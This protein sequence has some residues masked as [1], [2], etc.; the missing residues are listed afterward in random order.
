LD[1]IIGGTK[2]TSLP[3]MTD[4]RE[5]HVGTPFGAPSG[6]VKIGRCGGREVAFLP[7]HGDPHMLAPHKIN[8]RA[9]L[10][11][12]KELGATRVIAIATSGGI[13]DGFDAGTIVVPDQIIDYTFGRENT[14]F[15][16]TTGEPVRHIDVT[17]PYSM[18]LRAE[19]LRAIARVGE[20]VFDG[21]CYNG[22]RLETAAEIRRLK[23]DGCDLVG[24]TGMPETTLAREIG[25]EYAAICP[26]VNHAAGVGDSATAISHANIAAVRSATFDR[27]ANILAA[28]V[29]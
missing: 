27:V 1:A 15:D 22:P 8:Y 19:L 12:L 2:L 21:G 18:E 13:R 11:A 26:I 7:R 20:T 28:F 29:S 5:E 3:N 9:N 10:W 23:Q 16:G 24:Q 4:I 6:P 14:F 25:L 17:L